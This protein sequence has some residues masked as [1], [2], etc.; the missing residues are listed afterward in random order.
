MRDGLT[1]EV[2][3]VRGVRNMDPRNFEARYAALVNYAGDRANGYKIESGL[4]ADSGT[5]FQA[6]KSIL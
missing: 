2:K 4:Y 6:F 3:W 5:N 1:P